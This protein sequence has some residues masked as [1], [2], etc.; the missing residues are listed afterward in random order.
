[1]TDSTTFWIEAFG[2]YFY[3]IWNLEVVDSTMKNSINL[4]PTIYDP[5]PLVATRVNSKPQFGRVVQLLIRVPLYL[6]LQSSVR[7]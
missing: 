4:Q 2:E 6:Q 3:N 1:M 7:L 5:P